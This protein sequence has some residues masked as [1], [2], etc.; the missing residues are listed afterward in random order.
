MM[1]LDENVFIFNGTIAYINDGTSLKSVRKI[2]R[3][4]YPENNLCN[5]R[6]SQINFN[7]N[8]ILIYYI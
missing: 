5:T 7:S 1:R 4:E 6:T 8:I 2:R 3:M